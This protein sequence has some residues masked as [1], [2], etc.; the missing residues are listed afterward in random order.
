MVKLQMERKDAV[1]MLAEV[2]RE[3]GYAGTTLGIINTRTGIGKGSL[4]HFFPG[5]K[6]EM[7][8]A[9]LDDIANWFEKHIFTPLSEAEE[10]RSAIGAM[11]D[12]VE[13]Y[14]RAGRRICLVGLIALDSSR[15]IFAGA[16]T[17]YFARWRA[18]LATAIGRSGVSDEEALRLADEILV[19]IQGAIVL[20]RALDNPSVFLETITTLRQRYRAG[21]PGALR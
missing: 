1:A 5:G 15:D 12:A 3:H 21:M 17:G 13:A 2:F 19:G 6:E 7:A 11:F 10:P 8:E 18:T 9:V 4:Y 16:V 20:S 14:F